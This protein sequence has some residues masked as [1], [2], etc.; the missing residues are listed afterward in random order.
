MKKQLAILAILASTYL[1]A[2]TTMHIGASLNSLE[3]SKTEK[4]IGF[5]YDNRTYFTKTYYFGG[6]IELS[7]LEDYNN[8]YTNLKFG[9]IFNKNF[10]LYGIGSFAKIDSKKASLYGFGGGFGSDYKISKNF[11][12]SFTHT[13]YD[14]NY[15][16]DSDKSADKYDFGRSTFNL[17]YIF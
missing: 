8:I 2:D 15:T 9:Y 16:S 4:S 17:G 1:A 11:L 6:G 13:M 5:S 12:I 14:S 10:S 3:D 7:E